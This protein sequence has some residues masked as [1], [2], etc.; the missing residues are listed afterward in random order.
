MRQAVEILNVF[1]TFPVDTRRRFNVETSYETTS[2]ASTG[3]TLK[4]IFWKTKTFLKKTGVPF[5][6]ENTY[7]ENVLF[8]YKT[9]ISD[10]EWKGRVGKLFCS[11]HY[12]LVCTRK[13][14]I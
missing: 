13:F 1:S 14:P 7:I 10:V 4:Q 2:C 12:V 9:A 5:L 8:P 11:Y 6:V 3:L